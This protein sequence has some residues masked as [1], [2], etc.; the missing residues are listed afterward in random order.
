MKDNIQNWDTIAAYCSGNLDEKDKLKFENWIAESIENKAIFEDA[1]KV[2]VLAEQAKASE[3]NTNSAWNKV[4]NRTAIAIEQKPK[5]RFITTGKYILR[6]AA[7]FILGLFT[8]FALKSFNH[9]VTAKAEDKLMQLALS[10][11][12]KIDLN[13]GAQLIYPKVFKGATREVQLK[14]EAFFTVAHNPEKPFIIHTPKAD[15]KVLGTSFNVNSIANGDVE[16]IVKT[17]TVSVTSDESKNQ[18]ILYKDEKINFVAKSGEMIKSSNSDSNFLFW[19]TH[20]LIFK[21]TTLA[22]VFSTIEKAYHVKVT[23]Q[24]PL[25]NQCKLTATYENLDANQV[26][27]MI[28][29]TFGLKSS[30]RDNS[31]IIEGN[32]CKE[33]K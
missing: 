6:I 17:G 1:R 11:G 2:W 28:E 5:L 22:N 15:I 23:V 33:M 10:D 21:E 25:I 9:S 7:V 14:G 19:K 3:I 8:W 24:N 27:Q 26:I 29:I 31:F 4:A 32:R 30:F 18:V 20:K 12:S 13:K 16:V